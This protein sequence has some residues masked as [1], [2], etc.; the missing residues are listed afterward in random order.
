MKQ[1]ECKNCKHYS[2]EKDTCM[3]Y[4]DFFCNSP[5]CMLQEQIERVV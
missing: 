2:E 3:C 5:L 4:S 1:I